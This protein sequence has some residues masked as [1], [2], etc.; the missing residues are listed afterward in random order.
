MPELRRFAPNVPVVLVGTKL[1]NAIIIIIFWSVNTMLCILQIILS[2][3]TDLR[4]DRGFAADHMNS[5]VIT[6][7]QVWFLSFSLFFSVH[8]NLII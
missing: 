5:N 2:V 3:A 6:S 4:E 7:T 1:G 8:F